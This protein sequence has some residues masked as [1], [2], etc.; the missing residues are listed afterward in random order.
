MKGIYLVLK[1]PGSAMLNHPIKQSLVLSNEIRTFIDSRY[2]FTT[3]QQYFGFENRFRE[4][5]DP[6]RIN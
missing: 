5:Q 4:N 1:G 2:Y 3:Q 6:P